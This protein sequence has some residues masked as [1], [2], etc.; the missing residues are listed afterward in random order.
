MSIRRA[1]EQSRN[2]P[3]VKTLKKV[4]LARASLF[5]R[6]M[7]I[8]IPSDSG[9]SVGIGANASTLQMASAYAAFANNGRYYKPQFVSKIETP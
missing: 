2:V 8:N 3:A 7:G 4:G 6:K 5:V 1:L 9:L